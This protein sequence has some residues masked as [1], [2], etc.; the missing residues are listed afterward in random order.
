M[1]AYGNEKEFGSR[2]YKLKKAD[3]YLN[4]ERM[5]VREPAARMFSHKSYTND[6]R[7]KADE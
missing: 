7:R 2:Q 5:H 4:I 3:E 1:R 6:F